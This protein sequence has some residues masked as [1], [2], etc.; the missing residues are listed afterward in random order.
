VGGGERDFSEKMYEF[1]GEEH[2][3]NA[4]IMPDCIQVLQELSQY[5]EF[6]VVTSRLPALQI[7]TIHWLKKHF[8][9]IFTEI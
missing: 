1:Y 9:N 7:N 4:E 5:Y 2:Y 8:P 6:K 3:L